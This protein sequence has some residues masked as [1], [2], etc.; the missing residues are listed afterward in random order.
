MGDNVMDEIQFYRQQLRRYLL[1]SLAF[2][3]CDFGLLFVFSEWPLA[4]PLIAMVSGALGGFV[5]FLEV[6]DI[7]LA[8]LHDTRT[9]FRYWASLTVGLVLGLFA[10]LLLIDARILRL[11]YPAASVDVAS[12][13]S[14]ISAAI[15]GGIAGLLTKQIVTTAR[16]RLI[17]TRTQGLS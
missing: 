10:Y 17:M 4:K 6:E 5:R 13:P 8:T 15:F 14:A 2:L 3:V 16:K 12:E 9:M 1:P 11:V 7:P